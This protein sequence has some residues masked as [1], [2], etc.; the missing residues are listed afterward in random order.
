MTSLTSPPAPNWTPPAALL[1]QFRQLLQAP[2]SLA[3]DRFEAWAWRAMLDEVGPSLLT[4][5]AAPAHVTAS[6]I[7]FDPQLSHTLLVLHGRARIWV[8]P[9]GHLEP[10]DL[11]LSGAAAREALEET[12]LRCDLVP[13]PPLLSRHRAPCRPG[14]VDWHL[15]VQYA[16]VADQ[17]TP[18]VSDE[19]HDVAWV[20]VDALPEPLAPNMRIH[21]ARALVQAHRD[22]STADHG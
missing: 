5:P 22:R 13:V 11:S 3:E 1:E 12:G 18:Q 6:A 15:D 16:F 10:G 21:E 2:Q 9:G 19:S 20:S 8:Q 4:R 7:V 17:A 14:E